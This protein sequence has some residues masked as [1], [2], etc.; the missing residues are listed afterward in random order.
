MY[1]WKSIVQMLEH[2]CEK[3]GLGGFGC[4][5]TVTKEAQELPEEE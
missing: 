2:D 5:R 3:I 4:S 1:C